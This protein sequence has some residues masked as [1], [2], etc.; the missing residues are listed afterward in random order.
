MAD[1]LRQRVY[2]ASRRVQL[3]L[4]S[5]AFPSPQKFHT[6]TTETDVARLSS[7]DKRKLKAKLFRR[8]QTCYWCSTPLEVHTVTL[9]H[10]I[11]VSRGGTNKKG[12]Q[13]LSCKKCNEGRSNRTAFDIIAEELRQLEDVES[14]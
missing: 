5:P 11:P 2:I 4:P 7:T 1:R 12:N 6:I 8:G 10:L 3:L 13:V 9:D 14:K